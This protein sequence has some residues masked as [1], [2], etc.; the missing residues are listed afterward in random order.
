MICRHVPTRTNRRTKAIAEEIR[1]LLKGII[2]KREKAMEREGEVINGDLLDT[3]MESNRRETHG[4]SI[5]DVIKECKLFYFAG[6]ETTSLLLVWT[7][8]MLGKHQ[9]W[10]ARARDEVLE[11]FGEKQPSYDGL[12][13]LKIVIILFQ[14]IQGAFTLSDK[15]I[16]IIIIIIIVYILITLLI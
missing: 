14:S 10:Q 9:E 7:M 11:V 5:E 6:S 13:R 4:M 8:V 1:S 3:L 15:S 2:N 12:S 16:Y